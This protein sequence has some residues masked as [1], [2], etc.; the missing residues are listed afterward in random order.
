MESSKNRRSWKNYLINKKV[1]LRITAINLVF[2]GVAVLL[3]TAIMLSSSLC[4]IFYTGESVW[5]QVLDM[6]ALSSDLL[7]ISLVVAFVL[8]VISQILLTHQ[9]CGPLINFSHSFSKISRGD[10][11]RKVHLRNRDLLKPEADQFNDMVTNLSRHIE[12]LKADNQILL[13]TLKDVSAD[14]NS[15][16]KVAKTRQILIENEQRFQE[17]ID[18]LKV[19]TESNLAN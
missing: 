6:Y 19:A 11:T 5:T 1:Q 18:K 14:P 17:H 12:A 13:A 3:N 2:M 4:N 16:E 8:A 10:L 9:F 7:V 15:I